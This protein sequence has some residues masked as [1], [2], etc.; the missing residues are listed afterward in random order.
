MFKTFD[1]ILKQNFLPPRPLF[2][3][4]LSIRGTIPA[5]IFITLI[6]L[7]LQKNKHQKHAKKRIIL[8]SGFKMMETANKIYI[9][10]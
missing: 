4:A 8:W 1:A 10:G 3:G 5:W 9:F 6:N 7:A 2:N